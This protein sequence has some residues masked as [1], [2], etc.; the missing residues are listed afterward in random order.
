MVYMLSREILKSQKIEQ[1]FYDLVKDKRITQDILQ[2]VLV[3]LEKTAL[4]LSAIEKQQYDLVVTVIERKIES[5]EFVRKWERLIID[6]E[7]EEIAKA[8][9][10]KAEQEDYLK[11]GRAIA[12]FELTVAKTVNK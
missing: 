10:E 2:S 6:L 11:G 1:Y 4:Q 9:R 8:V 3:L 12:L 5:V 7:K